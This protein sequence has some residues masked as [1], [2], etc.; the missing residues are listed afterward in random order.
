M[1]KHTEVKHSESGL[2][3][4]TVELRQKIRCAVRFPL[5]LPVVLFTHDGEVKAETRNVSANGV[6]FDLGACLPVGEDIRFSMR[7]PGGALG[8]THDV[9]V[10]CSGRVVRCSSTQGHFHAAATI[11]EYQFVD[12]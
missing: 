8:S 12:Q 3:V 5:S 10:R 9:M 6:L 11:D 1:D 4:Q 7:M 2:P